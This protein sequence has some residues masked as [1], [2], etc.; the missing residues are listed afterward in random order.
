MAG[1]VLGA[2]VDW[3]SIAGDNHWIGFANYLVVWATVH[4]LGFAWLD[5]SLAGTHRRIALA[6]VGLVGLV[7][8]VWAG[9]Y[10][11]SMIGVD[12][13]VLNNS[14]PTRVTLAFLGMFQAGVVLLVERRLAYC[15]S[16][17]GSGRSR[18]W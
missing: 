6:A 7:T 13:A 5:G 3:W 11:I 1:L 18:S 2:L 15:S 16:A 17:P 9:P 10:P 4:Q 12:G 14:F 8:L